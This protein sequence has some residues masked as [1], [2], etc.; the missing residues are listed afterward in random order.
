L[1]GCLLN[2][3]AVAR[4][5]LGLADGLGADIAVVCAGDEGSSGED[6]AGAQ[7]IIEAAH[8]LRPNL[9]T[10]DG[11]G[12][13]S[14]DVAHAVRRS[15]HAATLQSIGLG[16]DVEYCV[17]LDVSDVVPVLRPDTRLLIL[18]QFDS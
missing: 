13:A 5:A 7:A 15:R 17:R 6:L 10:P 4:A 3:R 18:E 9:D 8:R 14:M 1:I 16:E 11:T 2:R 12:G